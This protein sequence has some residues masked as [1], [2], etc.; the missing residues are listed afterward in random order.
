MMNSIFPLLPKKIIRSNIEIE[1]KRLN[2]DDNF[3]EKNK[4]FR[5]PQ[6][7]HD[8]LNN[9]N[10]FQFLKEYMNPMNTNIIPIN[11]NISSVLKCYEITQ[12]EL[13]F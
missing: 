7:D 3:S 4:Q 13:N 9:D 5:E 10:Q 1:L 6:I 12:L 2:I 11:N 8:I